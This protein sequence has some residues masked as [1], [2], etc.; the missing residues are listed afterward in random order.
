MNN[1]SKKDRFFTPEYFDSVKKK[2]LSGPNGWLL[3]VACNSGIDYALA[4]KKEYE[5]QLQTHGSSLKEIPLLGSHEKPVTRIF[6]DTESCP[7]LDQ[8]VAG[9][10]A[11]V[12]QCVRVYHSQHSQRKYPT[13]AAGYQNPSG[14]PCKTITAVTPY[15]PYS[16][17]DKPSF[18]KREATSP[19]SSLIS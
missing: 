3:F 13:I 18:L 16:R 4:V 19:A 5:K 14:T 7:R 1:D 15:C 9:S 6:E 12:F 2:Q 10:N 11:F 17:Q 8:H